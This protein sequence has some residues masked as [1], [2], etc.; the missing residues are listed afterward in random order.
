MEAVAKLIEGN[1]YLVKDGN[2]ATVNVSRCIAG[3]LNG[4]ASIETIESMGG[5]VWDAIVMTKMEFGF[6]L[7]EA[8]EEGLKGIEGEP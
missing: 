1:W 4:I 3:R 2:D 7:T 8:Y 6:A 5:T